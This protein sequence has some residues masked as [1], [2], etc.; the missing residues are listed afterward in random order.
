MEPAGQITTPGFRLTSFLGD[1]SSSSSGSGSE[2]DPT[3]EVI[4]P[5]RVPPAPVRLSEQEYSFRHLTLCHCVRGVPDVD[6]LRQAL[7]RAVTKNP[8]VAG[9][10]RPFWSKSTAYK[11]DGLEI[12]FDSSLGCHFQVRAMPPD[13]EDEVEMLDAERYARQFLRVHSELAEELGIDNV[14]FGLNLVGKDLPMCIATFCPGTRVSVIALSISRML[15]ESAALNGFLRCWDEEYASPGSSSPLP[16]GGGESAASSRDVVLKTL[17]KPVVALHEAAENLRQ[18]VYQTTILSVGGCCATR[19]ETASVFGQASLLGPTNPRGGTSQERG[20]DDHDDAPEDRE[21][22]AVAAR[23]R[24]ETMA[25]IRLASMASAPVGTAGSSG[26]AVLASDAL[27]AW[28]GNVLRAEQLL[29]ANRD[30]GVEPT[31]CFFGQGS[32]TCVAYSPPG[33]PGRCH[34]FGIRRAINSALMCRHPVTSAPTADSSP[35]THSSDRQDISCTG[36]RN[37]ALMDIAIDVQVFPTF[38]TDAHYLVFELHDLWQRMPRHCI[39]RCTPQ[40]YIVFHC[41]WRRDQVSALQQSWRRVGETALS[42]ASE[43]QL[44]EYLD[45]G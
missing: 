37:S 14:G 16:G 7:Q 20:H 6:Q 32:K 3:A 35:S 19:G 8:V 38:G 17:L 44:L 43:A 11:P 34:A 18:W 28:L 13:I 39:T 9:R 5:D 21:F 22:Y 33:G 36:S 2:K 42:V 29:V 30:A 45:R 31:G 15:G 25:S 27:C 4:K 10:L 26:N 41:V 23:I 24:E 12:A 1:T 40:D